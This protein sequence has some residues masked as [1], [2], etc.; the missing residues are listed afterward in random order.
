MTILRSAGIV[1]LLLTALSMSTIT[2]YHP[3]VLGI[4]QEIKGTKLYDNRLGNAM[5]WNPNDEVNMFTIHDGTVHPHLSTIIVNLISPEVID[6]QSPNG[7]ITEGDPI[8]QIGYIHTAEFDITCDYPPISGS[9]I[10]YA[11]INQDMNTIDYELRP[12]Q[13]NLTDLS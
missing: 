13:D 6:R 2:L 1:L 10:N 8:C 9:E 11:V 4:E 5:G 3:F 7:N 12:L